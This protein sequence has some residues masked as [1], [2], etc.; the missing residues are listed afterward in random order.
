[1]GKRLKHRYYN[2]PDFVDTE[3]VFVF[4][5][6]LAG[7]HREAH[8]ELAAKSFGA[9]VGVYLGKTGNSY[10]IPIKN[11]FIQPL[12]LNQIKTYVAMFQQFAADQPDMLFHIARLEM[13]FRKG[14]KSWQ[15]ATMFKGCGKNC[16]FPHQ[17][18]PYLK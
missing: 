10:A 15:I 9:E 1:M 3:K 4:G 8:N 14:Y 7:L 6:N 18:K 5:S 12:T 11:R 16:F 17:W 13:G 2:D